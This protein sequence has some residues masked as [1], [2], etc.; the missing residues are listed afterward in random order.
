MLTVIGEALVD[1][2]GSRDDPAA[3]RALPGGSPLNV[4]VGAARLELPTT[5]LARLS[6]DRFGAMLRAHAAGNGVRLAGP[7][8]V[9][10]PSTLA[11][12]SLDRDGAASYAFYVQGTADRQWT[13]RELDRIPAETAVVHTGSLAAW[14]APGAGAIVEAMARLRAGGTVLLTYDPNVR[15]GLLDGPAAA[16]KLIEPYLRIAHLVKASDADLAWLYPGRDP[17]ESARTWAAAG[18]D[19]VVMTRGDAGSV[20]LGAAGWT[21]ARPA[22]PAAVIDTVGAGDAFMAGLLAALSRRSLDR[23]GALAGLDAASAGPLLDEAGAVAAL[24][25]SRAG[26]NP[27]TASEL[28]AALAEDPTAG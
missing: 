2:V 4:A 22:R 7:L 20:A 6:G 9:P 3:Y 13:A 1:L 25:C 5:L 12:A 26:A 27:P 11:I 23:A 28:A 17:L 21:I 10:E 14:L 16:A 24:T 15:P 19:L 8:A 18:P